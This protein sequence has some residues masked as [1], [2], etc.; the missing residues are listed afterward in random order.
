MLSMPQ[1]RDF[2][3]RFRPAGSPGAA[4]AGVPADRSRELQ[5]EVGPVLTLLDGTDVERERIIAQ[6]RREAE[7]ITAAARAEAAAIAA[8]AAQRAEEAREEAVR[9]VMALARDEAAQS[10]AGARRQALQ[11]RELARQRMPALVSRAVEEIRQLRPAG[12]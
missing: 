12:T 1:L 8:A 2:L 10:V 9:Q 3:A 4:R 6:A 11:T 5:A 7:Q